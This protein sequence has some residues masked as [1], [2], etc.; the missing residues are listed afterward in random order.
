[1]ISGARLR[2]YLDL[3]DGQQLS[4][5]RILDQLE[6]DEM[7]V[8]PDLPPMMSE[9]AVVRVAQ[10]EDRRKRALRMMMHI[11]ESVSFALQQALLEGKRTPMR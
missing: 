11:G 4:V 3:P 6:L 9:T 1:M 7:T 8:C 2:V 5:N 10:W